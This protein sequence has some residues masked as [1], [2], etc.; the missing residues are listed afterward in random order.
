M[1]FTAQ[2]PRNKGRNRSDDVD[3]DLEETYL[4][5]EREKGS[6]DF[7]PHKFGDLTIFL[8]E[9]L[10]KSTHIN[11]R[12]RVSRPFSDSPPTH[13]TLKIE[14]F[15]LLKKHSTSEGS[16]ESGKFD[17]GGYKW[18]L[19][20]YP[21]GNKKKNVEDHIS[22]YLKMAG[23]NSLETRWEV[24]VDFRLFLL[25]QN[26]GKYLVLQDANLNKICLH[27]AMLEMGF[28]RVIP[29]KAFADA[30]N[31]YLIDD[32]CV[33][34]AEVFVCKERRAGK[35]ECLSGIN[36]A[37]TNKY[38]WKIEKF[39]KSKTECLESQP[40]NAG[41]QTW[42]IKLYPKGADDGKGTHVSIYLKCANPEK[43]SPGSQILTEFTLRIVDQ[44]N[45]KH[46]YSK[47]IQW[48]S[49]LGIGWSNFI[50]LGNFK[51]LD[52]GYL[53]KDT[54]LIEAEVTVHGIA[55]AL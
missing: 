24:S 9:E 26:T 19:V 22:V 31:G 38:V 2:F 15:S 13:Y 8:T 37:S 54:C 29:L 49:A 48:F 33:F 11:V 51:R 23:A 43:L 6:D 50:T 10:F 40:F 21:N 4:K 28:D 36:S 53:L 42:K 18:K 41:G 5:R 32:K 47:D 55:K 35:A 52:K 3:D 20:V 27:R 16:F 7:I 34:G 12:D 45:A 44:L 1:N 39:S 25:D 30:S 14:A 46:F 17:A